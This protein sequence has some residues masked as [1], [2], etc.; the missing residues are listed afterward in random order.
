M[1][2]QPQGLGSSYTPTPRE[3]VRLFQ[4]LICSRVITEP[5]ILPCGYHCCQKCQ[6]SGPCP[7]CRNVHDSQ[8]G[9]IDPT[10]R[11]VAACF[12][13]ELECLRVASLNMDLCAEVGVLNISTPKSE[14]R[15]IHKSYQHGKL[16]AIWDLVQDGILGWE[17]D[18]SYF[19]LWLSPE[20]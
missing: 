4:C 10:L 15:I 13:T 6:P 17:N 7:I 16:L 20:K 18:I 8:H 2:E 1:A 14:S 5:L 9:R 12:E 3:T 11:M 19:E